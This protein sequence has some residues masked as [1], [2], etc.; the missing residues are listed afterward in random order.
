MRAIGYTS[1][2]DIDQLKVID[3]PEPK[4]WWGQ[5]VVE[6]HS[7]ALNPLDYRFRRGQMGPDLLFG[8][9][10]TGCDFAGTVTQIGPGVKTLAVGDRVM[11]MS[12]C[13]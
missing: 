13:L 9:R 7:I 5:V 6:V 4:A 11:G 10:V 1:H 2:G 3:R 12:N 8:P